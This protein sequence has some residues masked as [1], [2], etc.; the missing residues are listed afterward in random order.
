MVHQQCTDECSLPSNG[1]LIDI[2]GE[3]PIDKEILHMSNR[4]LAGASHNENDM[5]GCEKTF[6]E[7]DCINALNP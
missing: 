1:K 7:T 2:K 5:T 3:L 4:N 6:G